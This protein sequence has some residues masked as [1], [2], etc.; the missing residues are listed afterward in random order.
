N[1][2]VGGSTNAVIHL[3][4]IAGRVGVEVSLEDWDKLGRDVPTLLDLMP[5]GRFLMEDFYYAGG[6]TA[7]VRALGEKGRLHKAAITANATPIGENCKDAKT[8]NAEVIRPFEKPLVESGGIAV[9]QGNLAP[10]G[11]VLK[12]SAASPHLLT[13][14]GRA[15]VFENIEDYH[16]RISDP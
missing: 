3:L 1:G 2:A 5:S 15:V 11:A 9:L 7:I 12:P 14:R 10:D 13:H 6:L 16:A 4:A 8:W